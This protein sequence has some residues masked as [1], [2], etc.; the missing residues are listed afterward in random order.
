M[1]SASGQWSFVITWLVHTFVQNINCRHAVRKDEEESIAVC[2]KLFAA[3]H[4]EGEA[5]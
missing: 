1:I 2:F 5:N 3:I 4:F